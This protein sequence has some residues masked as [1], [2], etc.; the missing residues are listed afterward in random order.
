M[1]KI[2]AHSL[3]GRITETLMR[4]A[5]RNVKRHRGAAG[6]DKVSIALFEK[7]LDQNLLAL[8]RQLKGRT[9][10]PLP[11]RRVWI[12]KRGTPERRPLGI[13]V[14]RDRAGQALL[15]QALEPEWE[16]VFE[17][18]SYG[19]RPGRSAHDAIEA[20]WNG[21]KTAQYV[22]DADSSEVWRKF[23]QRWPD[24]LAYVIRVDGG[25][26]VKFHGFVPA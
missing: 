10:K 21:L 12:P 18:H 23:R 6:I 1:A 17:P 14:M 5:F 15:T 25:P 13:P 7:N 3:T 19:F 24:T 4:T 16:A 9:F 11:V 2:K 8:M 20:L 22:L 26:V